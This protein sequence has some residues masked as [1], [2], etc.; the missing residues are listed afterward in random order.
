[1]SDLARLKSE[2]TTLLQQESHALQKAIDLSRT[3]KGDGE[4]HMAMRD[5]EHVRERRNELLR[6]IREVESGS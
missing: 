3:G 5:V 4:L 1:M 2:L 6:R